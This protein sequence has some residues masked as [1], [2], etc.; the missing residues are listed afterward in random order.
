MNTRVLA[1]LVALTLC[2]AAV[3]LAQGDEEA[4]AT[5]LPVFDV[6]YD[7]GLV[8][9]EKSAHVAIQLGSG[10]EVVEWI[11]FRFDPMRYRS[12]EADGELVEV[13]DGLEWHPPAKGGELRYVFSID[14]LRDDNAYDS[15]CAKGWAIM[16]GEDLVPRMRI[17]TVPPAR[18]ES[19]MRVRLPEGW[20]ASLPYRRLVGGSYDLENTRTRFDRPQG[21]FAFGKLGVIRETIEG[22]RVAV[23][24]P[25]GQ[26]VRRMDILA[27][28]MWTMPSVAKVFGELPK[29]FQIVVAGDPMWR[30]GLS[31]PRSIYLHVDRPLIGHDGTSPLLHELVHSIMHANAGKDGDWVV[32]GLAEYY[33]IAILRRSNTLAADRYESEIDAIRKHAAQGGDLRMAQVDSATRAKAVVVLMEIDDAVRDATGG[34]HSLD[35]VTRLLKDERVAIT[36][37]RFREVVTEVAGR[38]VSEVFDRYLSPPKAAQR[39]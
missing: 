15:R 21:W 19:R 16:R 37:A 11:R 36:T 8:A 7:V 39:K 22:T 25:S 31:G 32:E 30:G 5:P 10:S 12:I 20:S 28:L 3:G 4:P 34:A 13:E 29:R 23:A 9:S 27:M 24:G 26:G 35:D 38:D 1:S 14:H 33:S 18:S 2:A 6:T 17:R